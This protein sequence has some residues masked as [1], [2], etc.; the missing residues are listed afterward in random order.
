M[1]VCIHKDLLGTKSHLVYDN[2]YRWVSTIPKDS[3]VFGCTTERKCIELLMNY[4]GIDVPAIADTPHVTTFR[5]LNTDITKIPWHY[6]LPT[7]KFQQLVGDVLEKC[8]EAL[9]SSS[10]VPYCG[11]LIEE[12]SFLVGLSRARIDKHKLST[13]KKAEKNPTILKTLSGFTPFDD[14]MCRQVK[15]NQLSTS[16]GRLTVESGPQILTLSKKYRDIIS[17]SHKNGVICQIDFV[18]LEPRVARKLS[19]NLDAPDIYVDICKNVFM[20]NLSRD[21]AKLAVLCALYGVSQRR[22]SNMLKGSLKTSEVLKQINR[23]F[24]AY[25]LSRNLAAQVEKTGIIRNFFGRELQ[26]ENRAKHVLIS[27]FLQSTAVDI[28]LLGFKALDA[29]LKLRCKS[30]RGLFVVHDALVIDI[31]RDDYDNMTDAVSEGV[32]IHELGNFP[33]SVEVISRRE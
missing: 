3:W 30:Y 18:S 1:S 7:K 16:T 33:L 28:S 13:Y 10:S 31:D 32:D 14:G 22:L 6:V 9:E 23:Y 2:N 8:Q 27:H 29:S 12:H 20:G 24:G 5:E 15:Y 26:V 4:L 19:G 25:S 21:E 17:S 11:T